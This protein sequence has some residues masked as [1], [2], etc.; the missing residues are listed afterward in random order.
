MSRHITSMQQIPNI[1]VFAWC[2]PTVK[3][4]YTRGCFPDNRVSVPIT[5]NFRLQSVMYYYVLHVGYTSEMADTFDAYQ[6]LKALP[7]K[8]TMLFSSIFD[9]LIML[10]ML[11]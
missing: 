3:P 6:T 9:S 10:Y 2:A 11:Q 7:P 1:R 4:L 8:K 5:G